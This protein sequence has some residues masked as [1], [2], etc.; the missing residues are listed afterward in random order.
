MKEE[1]ADYETSKMLKELGFDEECFAF[2]KQDLLI[3]DSASNTSLNE[4]INETKSV[5]PSIL[6]DNLCS[7]PSYHQVKKWLWEKHGITIYDIRD[8]VKNTFEFRATKNKLNLIDKQV[9]ML[10][11][12]MESFNSPITAEIEGIKYS[13]KYLYENQ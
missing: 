2:F 3:E 9:Q 1:L 8:Y 7:A 6:N 13:I 5:N 4:F 12:K 10:P 11:L